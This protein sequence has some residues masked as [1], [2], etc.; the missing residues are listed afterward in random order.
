MLDLIRKS[1]NLVRDIFY[2]HN[3]IKNSNYPED[4]KR[5]KKN[6]V[7]E[8]SQEINERIL[9]YSRAE[10]LSSVVKSNLEILKFYIDK[11]KGSQIS[12]QE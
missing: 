3:S 10:N 8:L 6:N 7:K 2:I 11:I 5:M 12:R 1:H 4:V 9:R